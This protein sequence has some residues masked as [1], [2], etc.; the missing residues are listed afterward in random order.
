[1]PGVWRARQEH[2][3]DLQQRERFCAAAKHRCFSLPAARGRLR[4]GST[5]LSSHSPGWGRGSAFLRLSGS[6][7]VLAASSELVVLQHLDPITERSAGRDR[8][9]GARAGARSAAAGTPSRLPRAGLP[10]TKGLLLPCSWG[11]RCL[12]PHHAA[13]DFPRPFWGE[14]R[15][16]SR[17]P[18][19]RGALRCPPSPQP[20][21]S[22]RVPRSPREMR[23]TPKT[24]IP[25][26]AEGWL[27]WHRAPGRLRAGTG[28]QAHADS[29]PAARRGTPRSRAAHPRAPPP[30]WPHQPVTS[31]KGP[32]AAEPGREPNFPEIVATWRPKAASQGLSRKGNRLR[33]AVSTQT[34]FMM[35]GAQM[36]TL[37]WLAPQPQHTQLLLFPPSSN[38]SLLSPSHPSPRSRP[39]CRCRVDTQRTHGSAPQSCPAPRPGAQISFQGPQIGISCTLSFCQ[40]LSRDLL[41]Q[42]QPNRS[43]PKMT[44]GSSRF[45]SPAPHPCPRRRLGAERGAPGSPHA[46]APS[47]GAPSQ[48]TAVPQQREGP[49]GRGLGTASGRATGEDRMVPSP[50]DGSQGGLGP[51]VIAN[52]PG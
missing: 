2:K 49:R 32:G 16:W 3:A 38:P 42:L 51:L 25:R 30:S 43:R 39:P 34:L 45:P 31:F 29:R 5:N 23:C 17:S 8:S 18:P 1:M 12:Q 26:G 47:R 4:S 13:G 46:A 50:G 33:R 20:R 44:S 52:P 14:T 11:G 10:D 27:W 7:G 21:G 28:L 41:E 37:S 22:Q 48:G 40:L 6:W 36:R 9:L 35:D 24:V 19:K 15:L